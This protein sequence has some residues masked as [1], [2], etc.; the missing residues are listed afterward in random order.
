MES[1]ID[2]ESARPLA[3]G[4]A[5]LL[6]VLGI[7]AC[8][9]GNPPAPVVPAAESQGAPPMTDPVAE[10]PAT[11]PA[12]LP[13]TEP[14]ESPPVDPLLAGGEIHWETKEPA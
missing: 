14:A 3:R 13:A 6:V 4:L 7:A 1:M 2:G 10:A 8:A 9:A 11:E 5:G 12:E